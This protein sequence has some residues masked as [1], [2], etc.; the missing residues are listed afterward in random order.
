MGRHRFLG[1]GWSL[2]GVEL[3]LSRNVEHSS[4]A[5]EGRFVSDCDLD[6]SFALGR[7]RGQS[8]WNQSL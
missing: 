3:A 5:Q 8:A 6:D 4:S 1:S 2:A 7:L